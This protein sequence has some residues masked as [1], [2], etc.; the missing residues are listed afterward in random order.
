MNMDGVVN[1]MKDVELEVGG[2]AVRVM[3]AGKEP[4]LVDL[5][6]TLDT[7]VTKAKFSKKKGELKV[8]VRSS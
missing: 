8:T 5:P 4:L 7:D 6:F 1:G 2:Q 3:A